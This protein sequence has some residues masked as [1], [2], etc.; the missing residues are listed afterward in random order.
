MRKT[1]I[2]E[3]AFLERFNTEESVFHACSICQEVYNSP[4]LFMYI[5]P[6]DLN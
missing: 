6:D 2:S 3:Y 1:T 4:I 5:I